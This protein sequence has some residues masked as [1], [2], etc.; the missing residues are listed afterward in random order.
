[1]STAPLSHPL[2]HVAALIVAAGR[3]ARMG[4]DIPKQYQLLGGEP[5]LTRTIRALAAHPACM[6]LR[7][8]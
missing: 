3:G 4:G 1:M 8:A 6:T 2:P 5:V 7:I